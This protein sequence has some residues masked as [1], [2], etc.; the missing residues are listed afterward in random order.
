MFSETVIDGM[1]QR[2]NR[3]EVIMAQIIS[4][5]EERNFSLTDVPSADKLEKFVEDVKFGVYPLTALG[6]KKP[7]HFRSRAASPERADSVKSATPEPVDIESRRIVN[8]M[9]TVKKI[10]EDSSDISMTILLRMDDKMNRQ[11]TCQVTEDDNAVDLTNELVRLGFVHIEDQDKIQAL[12]EETLRGSFAD[13][14]A[15][16][17]YGAQPL[18][19]SAT[20]NDQNV[21][22]IDV[23]SSSAQKTAAEVGMQPAAATMASLHNRSWSVADKPA[24]QQQQQQQ[25]QVISPQS[26]TY[27]M[28]DQAM[29]NQQQQQQLSSNSP[30]Q[31]PNATMTTIIGTSTQTQPSQQQQQQ[32]QYQINT[33]DYSQLNINPNAATITSSIPT[34]SPTSTASAVI[35]GNNNN[36][37]TTT[38]TVTTS[39]NISPP[40]APLN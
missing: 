8:M 11:L 4:N 19:F 1:M 22:S 25:G 3:P 32:P 36:T 35:P 6:G 29:A 28:Y 7:P 10:K 39:T 9:C 16:F 37:N 33:Q 5:G 14:G 21:S 20:I 30:Q 26:N 2:Y 27:I 24:A 40:S 38:T 15:A 18:T 13:G 17:E 23:S 12:L 34:F 31:I